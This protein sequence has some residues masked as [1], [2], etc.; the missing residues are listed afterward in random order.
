MK[1]VVIAIAVCQ[2]LVG[3]AAWA[4]RD[5]TARHTTAIQTGPTE[6]ITNGYSDQGYRTHFTDGSTC[7]TR[8]ETNGYSDHEVT[9]CR[10]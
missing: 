4:R 9:T 8:V 7:E 5:V 3:T 1:S 10:R 6:I 2:I